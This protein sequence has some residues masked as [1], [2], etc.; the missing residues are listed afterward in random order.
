MQIFDFMKKNCIIFN[1]MS[2]FSER[3][4][5]DKFTEIVGNEDGFFRND[6]YLRPRAMYVLSKNNRSVK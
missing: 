1:I 3:S 5:R 6:R 4:N 2:E